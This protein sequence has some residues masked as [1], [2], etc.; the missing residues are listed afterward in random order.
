MENKLC[1]KCGEL[2]NIL[3]F[4]YR[5]NKPDCWC[6]NCCSESSKT[7]YHANKDKRSAYNNLPASKA[8]KAVSEKK[9]REV[10]RDALAAKKK[11]YYIKNIERIKNKYAE[12]Y[13]NNPEPIKLRKAL[14]VD[15]NRAKHNANCMDRHTRKLGATPAWLDDDQK[16]IIEQIY[17][18]AQ[19]RTKLMGIKWHVDHI[20]PLRSKVV[21]GL[22]VP[23]N[24]QVIT[25]SENCSKRNRWHCA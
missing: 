9:Y 6:K 1:S 5:H 25:A 12:K 22:H 7:Y 16:W 13:A 3:L 15:Q 14:W 10:N 23:W 24:L 4:S 17:D 11:E 18:L 21:C 19:E 2:K 20:V 8:A